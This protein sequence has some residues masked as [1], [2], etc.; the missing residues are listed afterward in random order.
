MKMNPDIKKE[1]VTALSEQLEMPVEEVIKRMG[2][3]WGLV[4]YLRGQWPNPR[5]SREQS[6][7]ERRLSGSLWFLHFADMFKNNLEQIS[8]LLVELSMMTENK[9]LEVTK[10]GGELI[11]KREDKKGS[12]TIRIPAFKE[13]IEGLPSPETEKVTTISN[14]GSEPDGA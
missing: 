7:V 10:E 14:E 13:H 8:E 11:I 9:K 12:K 5:L 6:D 2:K 4:Q 3:P 1:I